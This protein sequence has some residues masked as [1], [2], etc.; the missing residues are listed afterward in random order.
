[1]GPPKGDTQ[2]MRSIASFFAPKT[3]IVAKTADADARPQKDAVADRPPSDPAKNLP[4]PGKAAKTSADAAPG[5]T[6]R[7]SAAANVAAAVVAEDRAPAAPGTVSAKKASDVKRR[8]SD[9]PSA[10]LPVSGADA[11]P[12]EDVG[13]RVA[14]W[15]KSERRFF[16][17]RV[18]AVDARRGKHHVRYDDGDDEWITVAK[19]RVRWDADADAVAEEAKRAR[20]DRDI[21]DEDDASDEDMSDEDDASDER[22]KPKRGGRVTARRAAAAAAIAEVSSSRPARAAARKRKVVLSDSDEDF[23]DD[24]DESESEFDVESEASESDDDDEDEDE[25]EEAS[26]SESYGAAEKRTRAGKGAAAESKK[27]ARATAAAA[28]TKPSSTRSPSVAERMDAAPAPASGAAADALAGAGP[29]QYAARERR[30][31][32]WLAPERR[33]DASGRRPGEPGYDPSTLRLPPGFPKCVDAD[34]K[35][36]TVSPGQAQWWR[37]KAAHFDSVVMFKMG[38]FYELFEMDAHVGA[39]D[40]GLA[41]MKGE[42]PHCGFPEKNYAANAERLARAGHRVVVVEQTETPAQLA[43]RRAKTKTKDTVV[44]REKVAVLTRGTLVDTAM[45]EASPDAAFCV[46]IVEGA[47]CATEGSDEG[48]DARWIGV[49]AADCAAGRFLVG[50]WLDDASAGGL[51]TALAALRPVEIVATPGGLPPRIVAAARDAAPNAVARA[52]RGEGVDETAFGSADA[53]LAAL[54]DGGYFP[55]ASGATAAATCGGMK[56]PDALA[57]LASAPGPERDAGL[58]AFAALTAYL[59]DCMLDGDLLPLGRVEALPGPDAAG[60]WAHGGFVALDAAA[61][62]GLEVLEDSGGGAAGS[63]LNA[64]DRCATGPGRRLL[65]QWLCRPLRSATAVAARQ[66]AVAELRGVALDAI[67]KARAKLRAAPDLERVVSRLV[68]AAGGRGRDAANVVLYEDAARARLHGFLAAL[69][70]MRA[71]KEVTDVFDGVRARI[72]SPALLALVTQGSEA[73]AEGATGGAAMPEL[74]EPLAFFEGAFDWNAARASGRVEPKPG[75]DPNVDAADDRLETA[76]DALNSWLADARKT[77]GGGKSEVC[78]VSANKDT[79]LVEVPDRLAARVPGD[80]SR[81]GKRKGFERFDSPEL[82]EL[83][84]ERAA[85]EEARENALAGVLRGLV[86]KFCEEWPRWRRAA[87]AAANLDALSSLAAHAEEL[88]ATCPDACTPVVRAAPAG[89]DAEPFLRAEKLRHP[90]VASLPSGASFVP[91]DTALGGGEGEGRR[92]GRREDQDQGEDQ[93]EDQ[94]DRRASVGSGCAPFLLLT[95][96]NMGGKSTL[97]RQVCLAALMAHV[98]AD[99]PARAFEMTATDAI[100]VRMGAKDNLVAGQSTFMVE[101]GETAAMLRRATRQS[102][103]ALDELG[104]GTATSDGAAIAAAVVDHLVR[105]GSRSLFSTHYHRLADD[106]ANDARV[107]L[108]HMGCEVKG[109]PGAEEV[110]FLYTLTE[111][112]CPKSYGVNVA[113]LAGLPESVLSA[114]AARS[115]ALERSNAAETAGVVRAVLDAAGK[116]DGEGLEATWRRA[117]R[118]A[119]LDA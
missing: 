53:A 109:E 115:A 104:R 43:E 31:F 113:R 67:G 97:L 85:A 112:A 7:A 95:G 8:V 30:L 117:R 75:A 25:D 6:A 110:T 26:E 108:G 91:N 100:F 27:S 42:Q 116:E 36:F 1:M 60:S 62:A 101:L 34:G 22:P 119:G 13:R 96:P 35:S 9:A 98:G 47:E 59:K 111:G 65:R 80:W 16:P 89:E 5:A 81:E 92:E 61:L 102:L 38:K 84:A 77:L 73:D 83:R 76:D 106:R 107:R 28:K 74:A 45:C 17:G 12:A 55:Q 10:D 37:F 20:G 19:R 57:A 58:G 21:S 49:A 41:Y 24:D 56:L 14:V 18:A 82:A 103:V 68:G 105:A 69:E 15:W 118:A 86:G 2:G 46:A 114:A 4:T 23:D 39:S 3:N 63:L 52:V 32:P 40:L 70:G 71:A 79:H 29:A 11:V 99:V 87:E 94:G 88:A 51:R 54:R 33:R 66:R 90:C 72:T 50:A 78:F 64:L 93:G 48:A 44:N